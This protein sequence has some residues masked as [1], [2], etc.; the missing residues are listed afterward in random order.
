MPENAGFKTVFGVSRPFFFR[1]IGRSFGQDVLKDSLEFPL[2]VDFLGMASRG[3]QSFMEDAQGYSLGRFIVGIQGHGS[4]DGFKCVGDDGIFAPS[5]GP[6]FPFSQGNVFI[7][8]QDKAVFAQIGAAD[9]PGAQLGQFPFRGL[10]HVVVKVLCD[11]QLQDGVSQEFQPFIRPARFRLAVRAGV[12]KGL[13]EQIRIVET[14]TQLV[15]QRG[16]V[17]PGN[18]RAAV[19]EMQLQTEGASRRGRNLFSRVIPASP[20][21]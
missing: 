5:A 12:G 4:E 18:A 1:F 13:N 10:G 2:G 6:F 9:G 20:Q 11:G 14:V 7:Q 15:F 3:I 17:H 19:P 8:P 16:V 21:L